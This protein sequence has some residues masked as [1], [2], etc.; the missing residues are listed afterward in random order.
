MVLAGP[1]GCNSSRPAQVFGRPARSGAGPFRGGAS[2]TAMMR[3][4]WGRALAGVSFAAGRALV[5]VFLAVTMSSVAG[6][7]AS[8]LTGRLT[9]GV[10]PATT[11]CPPSPGAWSVAITL[12]Q[13][14][15]LHALA[16]ASFRGRRLVLGDP[17]LGLAERLMPL[18]AFPPRCTRHPPR[19]ELARRPWRGSPVSLAARGPPSSRTPSR[20]H[21]AD[22]PGPDPPRPSTATPVLRLTRNSGGLNLLLRHRDHLRA[23]WI[24]CEPHGATGYAIA[25]ITAITVFVGAIAAP[26]PDRLRPRAVPGTNHQT[27]AAPRN[28]DPGSLPH[29]GRSRHRHPFFPSPPAHPAPSARGRP[30]KRRGGRR[31]HTRR[32]LGAGPRRQGPEGG[33]G[34]LDLPPTFAAPERTVAA[35]PALAAGRRPAAVSY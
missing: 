5:V 20:V 18:N 4:G 29:A 19:S 33:A 27:P 32:G 17:G 12:S 7:A 25:A 24:H 35:A 6:S 26:L 15:P 31:F 22:G 21:G 3:G 8:G 13:V 30:G 2:I 14:P 10:H 9:G 11:T 1:A 34:H 16:Q 28:P 23:E